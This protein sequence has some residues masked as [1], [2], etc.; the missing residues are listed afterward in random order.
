MN[1]PALEPERLIEITGGS[2]DLIKRFFDL[3]ATS[4]TSTLADMRNALTDM[5]FDALAKHAHTLKGA[6]ANLHAIQMTQDA[7][8]I[9]SHAKE[10]N[11]EALNADLALLEQHYVE[12]THAAQALIKTLN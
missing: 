10:A 12:F 11:S 3:F 5:D 4:Y 8:T 1:A 2:A 7:N 6:A 9:E